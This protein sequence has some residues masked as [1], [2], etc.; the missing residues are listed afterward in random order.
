MMMMM[1]MMM[2]IIII[3]IIKTECC[4]Y[5]SFVPQDGSKYYF[6]SLE[7]QSAVRKSKDN[8]L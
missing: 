4:V 6:Q 7:L 5:A 1:M 8:P 2:M 3:I